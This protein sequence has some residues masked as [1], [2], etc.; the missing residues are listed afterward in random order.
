MERPLAIRLRGVVKRFGDITAVDGLDLDVPEGTC[1]GLLGPN[2][3]GKSTT[4]KMLTAQAIA[5]AGELTVLG[6]TLP[7]DSKQARAECGV[8][9]Q[10]DNLDVELSARNNLAV[11]A[12]L[13]RVP[14][15][16]RRA[17]IDRA[18]AIANLTERAD[19]P[20]DKLSG[21]MRRR[22]LIARALVHQPRLMLLD[23]PTVGLDPQVR[24]ELWALI[25]QLR[26]EGTTILMTTH[27]IEEAERLA[28]TVAIMAE[29]Q[30]IARG[31]PG[32][33][34][35]EHAGRETG[36]GL[37]AARP[38]GCGAGGR[39]SGR[40]P[41]PPD[42]DGGRD[43]PRRA[44]KRRAARG[45][46]TRRQSGGRVRPADRRGDPVTRR[47]RRLHRLEPAAIAGV[48]SRDITNFGTYWKATTFS[49]VLE[50]TIYLLAFGLGLG[51]LVSAVQGVD[52]VEFV[53]TGTVATAVLFSSVFPA[54]F[55]VFVKHRFQR[56]YDAILAAPVDT[57]ELVTGEV[58]W[59]AIRAGVYGM[60]PL[61]VA[62]GFGLDPAVGMAVV[63]LIGFITGAGFAGFGVFMAGV[64]DRI[65]NFNYV[66]SA[67]ITPLF[68][69]SGTFFPIDAL[70]GWARG[71]AN[72]NPLYHCVELV[73]HAVF[74]FEAA[75]GWH[76]LALV[77]FA[78]VMWRLA[79][80]R[81]EKRLIA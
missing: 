12:R 19:T 46:A 78:L 23:E 37:R 64:V 31:R 39:R 57:E 67:V 33:L 22:L 6:Y 29:G 79:A 36:R 14:R 38:A 34:V 49:S 52:Y 27:Y 75:D 72:I 73:R 35:R 40:L 9:P 77:A 45:R 30:V 13:Y 11:F 24:Q 60:A 4:M 42:R 68:L 44:V 56:T 10:L 5:D 65:D 74:G 8:V 41:H 1:V 2:G 47:R 58:L 53:G 70:P 71:L 62:M 54:M 7:R 26:S 18:L 81:L 76:V 25:D 32:E 28:D 59:I 15:A 3:A 17:A 43:P 61:F 48:M 55:G 16:E 63:P 20:V 51:T 69:V 80:W 21:G 66:T 50:P